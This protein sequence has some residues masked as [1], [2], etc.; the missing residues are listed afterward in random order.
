MHEAVPGITVNVHGFVLLFFGQAC[1]LI[2]RH[3]SSSSLA[4]VRGILTT[5]QRFSFL[6]VPLLLVCS[7]NDA[8]AV[9]LVVAMIHMLTICPRLATSYHIYH[10]QLWGTSCPRSF[11]ATR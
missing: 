3:Y 9:L 7:R 2:R 11:T 1:S 4:W 10:M 5:G 8:V 6:P